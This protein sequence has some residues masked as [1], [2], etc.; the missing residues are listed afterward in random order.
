MKSIDGGDFAFKHEY[1]TPFAMQQLDTT[2]LKPQALEVYQSR[3][4]RNL[5]GSMKYLIDVRLQKYK[6]CLEYTNSMVTAL[7]DHLS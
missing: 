3:E 2:D 1:L 7:S 5:V 4:V 6:Q